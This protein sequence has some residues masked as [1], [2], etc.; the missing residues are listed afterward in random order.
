MY[1]RLGHWHNA[2]LLIVKRGTDCGAWPWCN[3]AGH[4][5]CKA[6]LA[7]CVSCLFISRDSITWVLINP[8]KTFPY[9][10][11]K[12]A[13]HLA[14]Y[15]SDNLLSQVCVQSL[16]YMSRKFTPIPIHKNCK[17]HRKILPVFL[18]ATTRWSF[19]SI[20]QGYHKMKY[21]CYAPRE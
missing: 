21:H 20:P 16:T 10:F 13:K 11:H 4:C 6:G 12:A 2:Q 14:N 17:H 5:G 15:T 9:S 8:S 18:K 7:R 3:T 1:Y 19:T